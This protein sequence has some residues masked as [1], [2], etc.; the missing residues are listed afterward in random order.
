MRFVCMTS[1]RTRD[2]VLL[3]QL[4]LSCYWSGLL[5]V[6]QHVLSYSGLV[7]DSRPVTYVPPGNPVPPPPLQ[8]K[9]PKLFSITS[10][11]WILGHCTFPNH[12]AVKDNPIMPTLVLFCTCYTEFSLLPLVETQSPSMQLLHAVHTKTEPHKMVRSN[13]SEFQPS[14]QP[15]VNTSLCYFSP[16]EEAI[17][18]HTSVLATP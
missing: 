1:S 3:L 9:L 11:V 13:F 5:R 17:V 15:V 4:Q 16:S 8:T 7:C 14:F 10:D 12:T 18:Y 6:S 2:S